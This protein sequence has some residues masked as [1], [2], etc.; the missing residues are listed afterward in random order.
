VQAHRA[1]LN[2]SSWDRLRTGLSN[3]LS[4]RALVAP[5]RNFLWAGLEFFMALRQNRRTRRMWGRQSCLQPPFQAAGPARKR[6]RGLDSPP[7]KAAYS[8]YS[9]CRTTPGH[10]HFLRAPR[11]IPVGQVVNLRRIVNPPASLG[12]ARRDHGESPTP[13]AALPLCGQ[14]GSLRRVGNPPG[15]PLGRADLVGAGVRS[16]LPPTARPSRGRIEDS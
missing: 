2:V 14:A 1:W 6:V 8:R 4:L 13:F 12:R 10:R 16:P 11:R 5:R 15:Y 9:A 7:H 3:R